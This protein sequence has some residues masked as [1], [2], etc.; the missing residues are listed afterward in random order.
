[1]HFYFNALAASAGSGLTYV[2]NIAQVLARRNDLRATFLLQPELRQEMGRYPNIAFEDAPGP[3]PA[4]RRFLWEQKNVP[5][6]IL[7]ARANVV[8]SAG[9]FALRKSPVPQI[10]LSGNSLYTSRDFRRDLRARGEYVLWADNA[11]K[12][13][14]A[15]RS[16]HWA[17]RTVAPSEAFAAELRQW[18]RSRNV[19]AIHHGFDPDV[20]FA[21]ATPLPQ[22]MQAALDGTQGCLRLLFVS[23]YNYFRNFETLLHGFKKTRELLPARDAKLF[24]TTRLL[25]EENPG[26]FRPEAAA[27]LV[28]DLG[29]SEHVIELGKVPYNHLHK[30]YRVCDLYVTAAYAETFAHPLVEAMACGVR[31]I[32]SDLLAHQEVADG[33]AVYFPRFS[34]EAFA[35]RL[36]EVDGAAELSQTLSRN[37]LQRSA[38]FSWE[39]HLESL[40]RLARSLLPA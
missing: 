33:A 19:V 12:S 1:M 5:K 26:A 31:I 29:L 18:T 10:L 23:H 38:D 9:N 3:A 28:R 17:D 7:R 14:F 35:A 22:A 37:G 40:L 2:R 15:S 25:F 16:V 30:L 6:L 39:K 8:V 24:L 27:A 11:I 20:F 36:A 21:D 13:F 34:P 4:A 32:A